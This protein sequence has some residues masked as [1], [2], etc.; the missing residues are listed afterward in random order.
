M[1]SFTIDTPRGPRQIGGGAP[2]FIVAEMSCNHLQKFEK[3][4]QI[5]KAAAA[6]GADAVKLQTYTADTITIDCDKPWFVERAEGNPDSWKKKTL[7]ELYRTAYT[8]WEWHPRLHEVADEY[9]IA[10]FSTPFDGTAVDFLETQKAPCYKIASYEATDIPLLKRVAQTGKPVIMSVGFATLPEIEYS[11]RILRENGCHDLALLHCLTSYADAPD[12][13][14]VN[15]RTI[16]DLRERFDVI[17]GFSDNNGGIEL[18]VA[19]ATLGAS[20]I[21][22]HLVMGVN[23]GSFDDRFSITPA[24][25][26]EM[27]ASIRRSE[28]A[29]G[30]V[31]Y[32]AQSAVEEGNK[33]FRRSL[34]VARDMKTGELFTNEN[35]RDIRPSHGLPTKYYDEII[36]KR[37][38]TDIERGTPLT[39]EMVVGASVGASVPRT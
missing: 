29:L 11:V 20:I 1:K 8:P 10:L 9:G 32:G 33:Y 21:E 30:T 24:Q 19:A 39:W 16:D 12:L 37:A 28:E 6:A 2:S 38:A 4:V 34:F 17:A 36:G 27:C 14:H 26:K 5:I 35:L 22:K 25:L 23:E 18:P 7:Y 31:R 15:L 13:K 3:A